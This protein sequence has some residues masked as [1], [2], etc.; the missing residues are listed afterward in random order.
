MSITAVAGLPLHH[1]DAVGEAPR[2]LRRPAGH[3]QQVQAGRRV[4][5]RVCRA[6]AAARRAKGYLWSKGAPMAVSV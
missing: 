6:P 4:D 1:S 3:H 5:R 2:S